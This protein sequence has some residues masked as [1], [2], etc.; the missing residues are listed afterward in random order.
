MRYFLTFALLF[1]P[2]F[3]VLFSQEYSD[4]DI[5]K[6][7]HQASLAF[8]GE[9]YEVALEMYL[10]LDS[11][12]PLD[13]R[14]NYLIGSTYMRLVEHREKSLG[15]FQKAL[16]LDYTQELKPILA[17]NSSYGFYESDDFFFNLARAYHLNYEFSVAVKYYN[18]FLKEVN[19][20]Y[21]GHHEDDIKVVNRFI[22]N[23]KNGKK[24]I[25]DTLD[26][27][28]IN[29]GP[30]INSQWEEVAPVLSADETKLIFTSRRPIGDSSITDHNGRFIEQTYISNKMEDGK[31]SQPKNVHFLS[32]SHQHESAVSISPDGNRL[33]VYKNNNH[34]TGDLYFSELDGDKWGALN[35]FSNGINSKHYESSATISTDQQTLYFS[36]SRPSGVG[37]SDL[38]IAHKDS[39][40][41]WGDPSNIGSVL[42]TEFDEDAP[43]IHPDGKTLYFSSQGHSSMGG[44][45]VF[46]SVY[47]QINDEW[48]KPINLGY[49]INSP[50][51][52]IFF[53]W[54]ADGKR[55]YFSTH[56][57]DSYG[58]EDIYMLEIMEEEKVEIALV[59][60]TGT[61][62]TRASGAPIGAKITIV[63]NETQQIIGEYESNSV[64]G[65]Y[66]LIL[67][68][69]NNYALIVESSSC[70]PHT[71]NIVVED[72]H[73]YY[74]KN[75]DITL[76][77]LNAGSV[78]VLKNVFF[79]YNSHK[80]K[81]SSFTE[82]NKF[83]AVL[84]N[85]PGMTVEVAGHTDS[86]G[87]DNYNKLLSQKRAQS[88]VNYFKRKGITVNRLVAHGYGE[89]FPI[90]TNS[91]KEGKA[92]NRRIEII[93]HT[94]D[95]GS[96]W[97]N[98]HY[99]LK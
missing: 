2:F 7:D 37:G 88:L 34:G 12:Q 49:P 71:E 93:V 74:E 32:E 94:K 11:I 48:S 21:H 73:V 50:E 16:D 60:L 75:I 99:N 72:R 26:V 86:D 23:C 4:K 82:L 85:N 67:K 55:A 30:M 70:L 66:T 19:D 43:F 14:F 8:E 9:N 57:E 80:L 52:D 51:N 64:T 1:V 98:G 81:A 77:A 35:R 27:A 15:Y 97:K 76:Q 59:M 62:T 44:F 18:I 83:Y 42:N 10:F 61:I 65:N 89:E 58:R 5:K 38:Y 68:P 36:S 39:L 63:N 24:I 90:A 22:E 33:I 96:E 54:T 40:G 3:N 31:W 87:T 45:D 41:E 29:L 47:D 17:I 92:Q 78:A 79:D 25:Q 20:K 28:I 95:E 46:K 56:H 13:P 91:T 6:I 53:V 69:G 84:V